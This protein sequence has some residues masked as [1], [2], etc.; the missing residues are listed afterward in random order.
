M[1]NPSSLEYFIKKLRILDGVHS[2]EKSHDLE[3]AQK[4]FS[5]SKSPKILIFQHKST[6][7]QPKDWLSSVQY[8][9]QEFGVLITE[10]QANRPR[11]GHH[12]DTLQN[13]IITALIGEVIDNDSTPVRL[14][15][16]ENLSADLPHS[17]VLLVF[18]NRTLV[19]NL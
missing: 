1:I 6:I 9:D 5:A 12:S 16:A 15:S 4:V 8:C 18:S 7:E 11:Q 3:S 2:I 10:K 13:R 14:K 17:L 19:G